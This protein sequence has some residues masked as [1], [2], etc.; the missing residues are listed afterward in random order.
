[1]QKHE[2]AAALYQTSYLQ[3]EFQLRSGV[4]ATEYFDKYQF[5]SDP[6]LLREIATKLTPL[7]PSAVDSLAGLELGA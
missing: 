1:M 7:V 6:A 5:E 3:G 4:I 2:L